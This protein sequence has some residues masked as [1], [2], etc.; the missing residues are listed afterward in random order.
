MVV[1]VMGGMAM[2]G[3]LAADWSYTRLPKLPRSAAYSDRGRRGALI[4][5][6]AD[7]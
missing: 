1:E 4:E 2:S 6:A 7:E 3:T 5:A